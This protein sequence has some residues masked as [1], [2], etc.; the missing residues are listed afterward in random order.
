[1]RRRSAVVALVAM[2][3]LV[4]T[5]LFLGR[6][7]GAWLVI[8]DPL[9]PSRAVVVFAGQAPFRA[10][11]AAA[12]HEKGWAREVWLTPGRVSDEDVALL[13]LGIDRPPETAYSRLVLEHLGVSPNSIRELKG[14]TANTAEE[15]RAVGR[16]LAA[17]GGDRVI[18]VTSKYHT[19]RVKALW[20]ALVGVHPEAIVRFAPGDPFEPDRWW[21]TSGDALAVSREWFGLLN[22]WAGFPVKSER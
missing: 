21:R 16:E 3:V 6:R 12:I 4:A 5:A 20:R 19:R 14:S 1:M 13:R 17:V 18:L 8:D 15:V 9:Q 22:A 7:A 10:M 2:L 11:E